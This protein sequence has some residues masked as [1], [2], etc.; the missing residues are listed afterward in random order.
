MKKNLSKWLF[1]IAVLLP[2][3]LTMAYATKSTVIASG[4]CGGE[5]DGTNLA[6]TL[7]EDGEL[8]ISGTGAMVNAYSFGDIPWYNYHNSV[9]SVIIEDG[10][11]SIGEFVFV[12]HLQLS[13]VILSNSVT[14]IGAQ[15]FSNCY[16][17]TQITIPDSVTQIGEC[18]FQ[19][20]A[21]TSVYIPGSVKTVGVGA[22]LGSK[23]T[24]VTLG[25]GVV[26]LEYGA[27]LEC[28]FTEIMIPSSVKSIGD[29]VFANCRNLSSMEFCGDAPSLGSM[30]GCELLTIF[31]HEGYHGWTDSENYD[32]A[33]GTWC[34]YPLVVIPTPSTIT[35]TG[36]SISLQ[37]QIY[38]NQYV[39]VSGF[40]GIDVAAKG[41]LLIWNSRVTEEEALYGTADTTQKG[42][43]A[44]EGEYTQRT[45]GI[46]A[47]NYSDE[48][49]LRVY[50]EVADGSFVYGP[51]TEYSVQDYCEH[52]INTEGYTADLKKTCAALLH[53]GAMA[54]RY[55]NYNTNDLAN[56]NILEV[57]PAPAW[58]TED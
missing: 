26:S 2:C 10:V 42:L 55:F 5:G 1:T 46:S 44:Y 47:K 6:W 54:Q 17:L 58:M 31:C 8:V 20:T 56:A 51:L 3:L 7:Y 22:F 11:T 14:S 30:F 16:A 24:E 23:L 28:P 52:K 49:Y 29:D 43:I 45:L 35:D 9:N 41:G 39:T 32:A 19:R 36:R 18:A 25:E 40:D 48:L 27:F 12:D 34:G 53:Y 4:Y 38:I 33:V 15:A 57:Y 13:S 21:L 50:I 37:D